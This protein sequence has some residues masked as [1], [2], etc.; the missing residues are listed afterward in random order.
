MTAQDALE[1][2]SENYQN[3][4]RQAIIAQ[5]LR[6]GVGIGLMGALATFSLDPANALSEQPVITALASGAGAFGLANTLFA[7]D[8]TLYEREDLPRGHALLVDVDPLR[9]DDRPRLEHYVTNPTLVRAVDNLEE[10]SNKETGYTNNLWLQHVDMRV[11]PK[12]RPSG[13]A[14]TH[15]FSL[16]RREDNDLDALNTIGNKVGLTYHLTQGNVHVACART[17][18]ATNARR[19]AY[20]ITAGIAERR[21]Q[22][23]ITRNETTYKG[24]WVA[25]AS[26]A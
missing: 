2:L 15:R 6:A 22:G 20:Q 17:D 10:L 1:H 25:R 24:L 5:T 19:L 8:R 4:P 3:N 14:R 18:S 23:F 26:R 16:D 12:R 13:S 7:L 11:R 21:H 9:L